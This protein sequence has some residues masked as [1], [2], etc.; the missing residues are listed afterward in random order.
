MLVSPSVGLSENHMNERQVVSVGNK[1]LVI[2]R[3]LINCCA[4]LVLISCLYAP[5]LLAEQRVTT[6]V[7]QAWTIDDGLPSGNI[8]ALAR[9]PDNHIWLGTREGLVR[10]NGRDF[11]V[12]RHDPKDPT[13]LLPTNSI[14]FLYTDKSG[15]LWVSLEEWGLLNLNSRLEVEHRFTTTTTKSIPGNDIWAITEACVVV[16]L[17]CFVVEF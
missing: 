2:W 15:R 9:G 13:S 1:Q 12:L 10:F 5:Q 3:S 8:A 17:F 4:S 14:Q 16:V 7:F 6:P 11:M